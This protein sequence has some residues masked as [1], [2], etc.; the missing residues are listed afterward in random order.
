MS[1]EYE[2]AA[3]PELRAVTPGAVVQYFLSPKVSGIADSELD[4][5]WFA[6]NDPKSVSGSGPLVVR[7]P[8]ALS[9]DDATWAFTGQHRIVCELTFRGKTT[10]LTY[11][12]W[13]VPLAPVLAQG[14]KLPRLDE[15]PGAVLDGV[16]R[17]ADVV[18]AAGKAFPAKTPDEQDKNEDFLAQLESYR[19]RLQER[20]ESTKNFVRHPV[21][22]EHFDAKT[23][24]RFGLR[25]FIS[26]I[27]FKK[28][29]IVDWTN[30]LVR[31]STGEYGGVGETD[32]ECIQAA[33]SDWDD[34]NRYPD[35]G[36]T[37]S[38]PTP[39]NGVPPQQG[40]FLTDGSAQW[41]SIATFFGWA[42]MGAAVA[43]GIITLLAPVPGSQLASAMIW[44]SIFSSTAA[45]VINIGTRVDEG[46]SSFRA[47]AFDVLTIVGN[48]FGVAGIVWSRGATVL[49][50]TERG[51]LKAAIIGRVTTD[52]VQ[53]VLLGSEFVSEFISI[54]ND[55]KLLPG[56]RTQRLVA[57]F[58][59]AALSGVLLYISVKGTKND[60][61]NLTVKG[62]EVGATTPAE[63]LAALGDP[64]SPPID[65]T[66]S[67]K[68][69]ASTDKATQKT[70]VHTDQEIETPHTGGTGKTVRVRTDQEAF[71]DAMGH[72][73][74]TALAAELPALRQAQPELAALTDDELI[75]I[76]GY[77]A[78]LA[79]P[80][81]NNLNDFQ[82]INNAMRFND[83][84]QLAILGPYIK[85]L[86]SGLAK[87]PKFNGKVFRVLN[88]VEP[89]DITRQFVPGKLWADDAFSSTS[90][91]KPL[92]HGQ[93]LMILQNTKS[94]ALIEKFAKLG[95]VEREVLFPPGVKFRVLDRTE[96]PPGSGRFVIFLE[97]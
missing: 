22:A 90:H 8:H 62:S 3:Q 18:I 89:A 78:D 27:E 9:W 81:F 72:G 83:T 2:I 33:I 82:R 63:R 88:N 26:K 84:Q 96:I 13:V 69:K 16:S 25:V 47:N 31:A 46:F 21:T 11:Q 86:T 23:Q 38:I 77:T 95:S 30:P 45:A 70:T 28:W 43:A 76:R 53:G 79:K 97:E 85:L 64:N 61:A 12:Q 87:V 92:D 57:L 55:K 65:L 51:L 39:I 67:P 75:A 19:D 5:Q 6:Y 34:D 54:Q 59:N 15:D 93:V 32:V 10:R 17:F 44:T 42:G 73:H 36:I 49:V 14:P 56:E 7:G 29:L 24:Q 52:A 74:H 66:T 40:N 1:D 71:K 35:G 60:L 48:L 58:R 91:G 68:V 41:D 50:Q 20:L 4:A 80:E 37:F 94:G